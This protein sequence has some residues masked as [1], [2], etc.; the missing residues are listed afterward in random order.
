MLPPGQAGLAL[1]RRQCGC[2][3]KAFLRRFSNLLNPTGLT[4]FPPCGRIIQMAF[5]VALS[6]FHPEAS[7]RA[8]MLFCIAQGAA[9]RVQRARFGQARFFSRFLGGAPEACLR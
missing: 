2:L 3:L 6:Y 4:T 7:G 8:P 1:K 9:V 5:T